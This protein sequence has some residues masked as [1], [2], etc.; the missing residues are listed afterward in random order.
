[1][2]ETFACNPEQVRGVEGEQK[3]SASMLQIP[4]EEL[5]LCV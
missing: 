1:M 5:P 3:E 4:V 2:M